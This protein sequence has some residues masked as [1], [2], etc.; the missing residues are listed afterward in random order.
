MADQYLGKYKTILLFGCLYLCGLLI[1]TLTAIPSAIASGAAF[2]GFIVAIIVIGLGTGGIKS[3]VSPLVAEQYKSKKPFVRTLKNGQRV[4]VTP[5]ATYQKIFNM[6][7]WGINVGS[8][9][10][11][12]TTEMEHWIGFW[13]AYLL[14]TCMFIPCMII[15]LLGRKRYVQTPPRGSVFLEAG[16]LIWFSFKTKSMDACKP[17]KIA[18]VRPDLAPKVT[19]DDIFV[20]EFKR[21]L[22]ACIVFCWYPIYWLC[23]SQMTNNLISQAATVSFFYRVEIWN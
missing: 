4:I 9:S 13:P 22:R 1:L 17:S 19:W 20:D 2:P 6:F 15:V 3:N 5:Q 8:L 14:P 18:S 12:A 16:R 23:Y 21:A 11:I 7:Y 10:S